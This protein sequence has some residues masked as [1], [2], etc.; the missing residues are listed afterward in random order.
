MQVSLSQIHEL[1]D[2]DELED[3]SSLVNEVLNQTPNDA[4]ALSVAAY[5]YMKAERFGLGAAL[6][7]QALVAWPNK[8]ELLNNL[9]M[10]ELGC[11]RL[12][13]A[14]TALKQAVKADPKNWAAMNNL[15]LV[16]VNK[17]EP[18]LALEWSKKSFA[19]HGEDPAALET[20]GYANLLLGNWE[21][22]W[23]GFEGG[24]Y[25][26]IRVPR[27]YQ[28]EPYWNGEKVKTL[29]IRGEQGVGD[30]ISFASVIR[31]AQ[32][33]AENVIIECDARLEG[34]FR[35]SF[36]DVP[37]YGTRF[38]KETPWADQY[39]IDAHVLSGSLCRYF[40][41][42]DSDFPAAPYLVTDPERRLQW[43]VLLDSLGKRKKVGI[44]WTGGRHNTHSQRRSMALEAFLPILRQD[45]DFISLQYKDPEADIA[46]LENSYGVKVRH[47]DRAAESWNIDDVAAL[48]SELDLV[49]TVQTAVA[50]IAGALGK[51]C[52]VMVPS[53]PHWRYGLK[54]DRMPWYGSVK[55]YRQKGEWAKTVNNVSEALAKWV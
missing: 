53:K 35:R 46:K 17:C 49:I 10:C 3:A 22:G 40:R 44:A 9:G 32:T 7:R 14:E 11:M 51:E 8:S 27:S 50:H 30:E 42:A 52:W 6:L 29:V 15:A 36:P 31:D 28:G 16:Y 20:Y 33:R 13:E 43:R 48:V 4:K 45:C 41:N 25:G 26:K 55:L 18:G 24:L 2:A 5:I 54:G 19:L 38:K 37:V 12:D 47:W 39:E 34:L 23:R 1:A 21:E